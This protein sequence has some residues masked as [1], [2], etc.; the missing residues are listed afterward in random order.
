MQILERCLEG[1]RQYESLSTAL[2]NK[3][4]SFYE[5][6]LNFSHSSRENAPC[7]LKRQKLQVQLSVII[8]FSIEHC[9]IR[10]APG[11][12]TFEIHFIQGENCLEAGVVN[13][14]FCI[15]VALLHCNSGHCSSGKKLIR[16]SQ[17]EILMSHTCGKEHGS[18]QSVQ[19]LPQIEQLSSS[20]F[21]L[22]C[23]TLMPVS[24]M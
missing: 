23:N 10:K 19:I 20:A 12:I 3:M 2:N 15:R 18:S 5:E 21:Q 22:D 11:Y 14:F 8:H 7:E 24:S 1:Q 16:K 13:F 9:S 6:L 4:T 17:R